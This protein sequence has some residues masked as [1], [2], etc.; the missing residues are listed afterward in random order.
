MTPDIMDFPTH[1]SIA[2]FIY[3]TRDNWSAKIVMRQNKGTKC[4]YSFDVRV[5]HGPRLRRNTST[6][7]SSGHAHR[8]AGRDIHDVVSF[9]A[10]VECQS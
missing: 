9:K 1:D 8:R 4:S 5:L 10:V 6:G 2:A 7:T 3:K